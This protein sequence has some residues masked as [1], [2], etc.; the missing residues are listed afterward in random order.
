MRD[1]M[2]L[3]GPGFRGIAVLLTTS[4]IMAGPGAVSATAAPARRADL[5]VTVTGAAIPNGVFSQVATVT[6]TNHGPRTAKNIRYR[7]TGWVGYDSIDPGSVAFCPGEWSWPSPPPPPPPPGH[8]MV[9]I[10]EECDLPKLRPGQSLVLDATLIPF[11]YAIG[12][13]GEFTIEV[14]SN[15]RDPVPGNST[16]TTAL[17]RTPSG[18]TAAG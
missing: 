1:M 4:A 13:I 11:G 10:G 3:R 9:E 7:L 6:V 12:M 15:R 5:S 2:T 8:R 18:G 16:V 14:A 17:T